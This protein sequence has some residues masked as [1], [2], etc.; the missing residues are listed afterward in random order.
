M[1]VVREEGVCYEEV[2]AMISLD[3]SFERFGSKRTEVCGMIAQWT[4][5][6]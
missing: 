2:E 3:Y 6:P 5:G 1:E 4:I